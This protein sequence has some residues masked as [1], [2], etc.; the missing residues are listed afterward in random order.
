M[1]SSVGGSGPQGFG[2]E[3]DDDDDVCPPRATRN[4]V[5]MVAVTE[6]I[7]DFLA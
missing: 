7:V 6:V 3:D 1:G 2:G 4:G 5:H